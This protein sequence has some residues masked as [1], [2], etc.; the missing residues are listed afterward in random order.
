MASAQEM[1]VREAIEKAAAL[2]ESL[3][4]LIV[5]CGQADVSK[6]PRDWILL[7]HWALICDY[8]K[9]VLGLLG[10]QFYGG[11]FALLR[12]IVEAMVRA[13]IVV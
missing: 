3:E 5:S 1:T 4:D 12:P 2:G 11:A 8:N 13:H 7:A 10:F 6:N 9:S